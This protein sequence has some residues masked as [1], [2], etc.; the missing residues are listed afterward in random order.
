[1]TE[2]NSD[3]SLQGENSQRVKTYTCHHLKNNIDRSNS[4]DGPF[5]VVFTTGH[6]ADVK[7]DLLCHWIVDLDL[8]NWD[9]PLEVAWE[10]CPYPCGL[11][12]KTQRM[13]LSLLHCMGLHLGV[14]YEDGS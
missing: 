8:G 7:T 4:F 3:P 10:A 12:L 13:H 6:Q 1:M 2:M 5:G 11:Y 14:E 9:C